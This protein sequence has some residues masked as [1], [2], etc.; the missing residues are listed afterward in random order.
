MVNNRTRYVI[1]VFL[2]LWQLFAYTSGYYM[3][4]RHVRVADI[5]RLRVAP[6]Q[7]ISDFLVATADAQVD[8]YKY[9]AVAAPSWV[10]PV[11][12]LLTI[13]T[14]AAIPLFLKPGQEALEKQ[15]AVESE[16]DNKFGKKRK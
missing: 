12:A 2:L 16:T 5:Q 9:G 3:P 6:L 8:T 11:G 14:A 15:R 13:A 4:V 7:S 10:L 1:A